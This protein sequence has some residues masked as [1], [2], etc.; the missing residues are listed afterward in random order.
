MGRHKKSVERPLLPDV[1]Y[2]SKVISKFVC[3][4]MLDGKKETC[5]K[6]VYKAMDNLK[7]KTDK[8]PLEVLLK[9]LENIDNIIYLIK[10]SESSAKAKIALIDKYKFT[11]AQAKAIVDMKLGKL[12]GLER[13][14]IQQD[15]K[16]LEETEKALK[17]ILENPQKEVL[18]RL[19]AIVEKYGDAR[20][21][22]LAQIEI[23]KEEKETVYVEPEK[24]VVVLTEGGLV[25]RVPVTSFKTQK[26]AT[27]GVK[28]QDDIT[29]ALI[30]TNT[31][32][33]LMVFT[34]QGNMYR[35]L[36]DNI[37]S[38]TNASKG[39]PIK[40]LIE[41]KQGEEP[42]IIYS[43]YKDTDAKYVIFFTKKGLI[44]KTALE[45]YTKVK[46]STGI[47]AIKIKEGDSIANVTF[48]KD[49]DLIL[50]TKNGI[51]IHFETKDI[52]PIGRVAAGVKGIKLCE[53][54]RG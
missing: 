33:S 12:A 6:I 16:E 28:T 52:N 31:V 44:K 26:R 1:K 21:T 14:E 18:K 20:R 3:R 36:V 23:P 5:V 27:K 7:A 4:M 25:K 45:E 11:E 37:P 29:S 15:A 54:A 43:I 32:D 13:V 35:L 50:V 34:N 47:A 51:A 2:N 39:A 30:R 10:N 49:E 8:D 38:G 53:L 22:E 40:T 41:M 42:T 9:A 24:C 46:R 19:D 48:V 17:L